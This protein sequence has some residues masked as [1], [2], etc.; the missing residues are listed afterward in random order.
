METDE[1]S[2]L[3][4]LDI[5]I[6]EPVPWDRAGGLLRVKA[7]AVPGNPTTARNTCP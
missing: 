3:A 2:I 4:E 6:A 1:L 5:L 7:E